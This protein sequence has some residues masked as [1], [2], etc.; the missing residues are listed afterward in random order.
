MHIRKRR[1]KVIK[2]RKALRNQKPGQAGFGEVHSVKELKDAPMVF[3]STFPFKS[4][5]ADGHI[6]VEEVSY[7]CAECGVS[8]NEGMALEAGI[9][10]LEQKIMSMI[11]SNRKRFWLSVTR[12][13]LIVK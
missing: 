10:F 4:W 12:I 8:L 7:G 1:Y 13:L 9:P 5:M 11:L 3:K 6:I 2:R